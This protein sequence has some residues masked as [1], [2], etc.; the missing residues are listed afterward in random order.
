MSDAEEC[1]YYV[2]TPIYYANGHP[3]IGNTYSTTIADMLNRYYRFLGCETFFL[4]GTDEHGDKVAAAAQEVGKDPT[5][6]T[7]AVSDEF[8]AAW[9]E[10]GLEYSRFIRTTDADHKKLVCDILTSIHEKGDIYFGE[11]EG[12]YCIGC[13]RFLTD[14][15]LV[16]GKCPDHQ[17]EPKIIKEQ[18]Y[19]FKLTKYVPQLRAYIDDHPDFIRP[20]RY[21]NEVL[22]IL[23]ENLDDLCIS[24]PKTRLDWG[25]ELP[26]DREYVTYVWFDA[27]INYLTGI[28]YP[29]SDRF[30]PLWQNAEH[31]IAKDILKP[32]GVYWPCM[33]MAAEIPV[34]KHLSVHG[35]WL[36]DSGKMSKSVGN[37]IDPLAIKRDFGMDAYR[38][39]ITREMVFGLDGKFSYDSFLARYNADL[40][41]N[42]GN[43]VSRSLAML[44]KY[45]AGVAPTPA[46][47]G[48]HENL[49]AANA[50]SCAAE[51]EDHIRNVK[52]H[53]AVERVWNLIDGANVYIDRVR[54]WELAKAEK[55]AGT[56]S[57]E[58]NT[59]LYHIAEVLRVIA[60]NLTAFLPHASASILQA[61]GYT[62]THLAEEQAVLA[63]QAWGRLGHGV[64]TVEI[65]GLFPRKEKC[66]G[67]G[68]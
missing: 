49:L 39:Y 7:R 55:A 64:Q 10:L 9:E 4:T 53:S 29:S 44:R 38:Y 19:F 60:A 65:E 35:Y 56:P 8:K 22:G 61:L 42:L 52:I 50:R 57:A 17:V 20:E 41:N 45:R 25:I 68:F 59:A 48:E 58:L 54:P 30:T 5:E 23:S 12:K 3:H 27:L 47:P 28:G 6:F 15:E 43:L 24:R 66:A 1:Y 16:D 26:F 36:T 40:A 51:V 37:V 18:N 46:N 63:A 13:E 14:K 62:Q 34:Y 21:R 32:H 2:T 33:L 11:Y 31:L 67:G